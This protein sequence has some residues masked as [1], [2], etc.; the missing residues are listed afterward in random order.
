MTQ[1][2]AYYLELCVIAENVVSNGMRFHL[3]VSPEDAVEDRGEE[4]VEFSGGLLRLLDA[5]L[6]ELV[7]RFNNWGNLWLFRNT[8]T[9]LLASQK[10]ECQKL[11][12]SQGLPNKF[13][14]NNSPRS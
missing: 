3:Q 9:K 8:L 10:S 12:A 5:C 11:V 2:S 4:R 14:S 7:W 6:V 1:A 13:Q